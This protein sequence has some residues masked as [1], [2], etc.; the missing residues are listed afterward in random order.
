[1]RPS[2]DALR[3]GLG[4]W[5]VLFLLS[6][7][8]ALA[9]EALFDA[10]PLVFPPNYSPPP[11]GS[12]LRSD[13]LWYLK[14]AE[15]GYG[16]TAGTYA[17]LPLFPLLIRA[18]SPLFGPAVAGLVVA[19]VACAAGLVL[20]FAFVEQFSGIAN[21]RVATVGMAVLPTAFFYVAP[22]AEP[23]LLATGA[24]ALLA[25]ISGRN[26]LAGI[27]GALAALSRPFGVLLAIP[28]AGMSSGSLRTRWIGPAG[29]VLGALGWMIWVGAQSGDPTAALSIQSVWQRRLSW[30]HITL[31]DAVRSVSDWAGSGMARYFLLDLAAAV[32]VMLLIA[33]TVVL[34]RRKGVPLAVFGAVT[35]LA[36]LSS[37]FP[38]RPLLSLP[39]FVLAFFPLSVALG[40]IPKRLRIPVGVASAGGLVLASALFV[41]SRPIF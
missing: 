37:S 24:G 5:A 38:P 34:L 6:A 15:Q 21:A 19:S 18:L 2:R 11:D 41:A 40:L 32:F 31:V 17:F 7:L 23:L 22:Y 9:S 4:S 3:W 14:I 35:F 13:A 20:L 12:W 39:R 36:V 26:L 1:M 27:L 10:G 8:G 30:P 29:P 33:G 28:L 16:D 25:A